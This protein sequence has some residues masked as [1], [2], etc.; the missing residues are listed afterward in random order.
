M[1]ITVS[2]QSETVNESSESDN[3]SWNTNFILAK[4]QVQPRPLKERKHGITFIWN[5]YQIPLGSISKQVNC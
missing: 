2:E 4:D 1:V 3:L 5:T